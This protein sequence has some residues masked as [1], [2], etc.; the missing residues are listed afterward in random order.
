MLCKIDELIRA[1]IV[2]RTGTVFSLVVFVEVPSM[3]KFPA[4]ASSTIAAEYTAMERPIL[5]RDRPWCE[6][7][8]SR[9]EERE[10]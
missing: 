5:F 10:N 4:M 3:E 9:V 1:A 6:T 2:T 7:I 8:A